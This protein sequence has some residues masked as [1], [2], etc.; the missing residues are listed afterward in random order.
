MSDLGVNKANFF[1]TRSIDIVTQFEKD[2][3]ITQ[4]VKITFINNSPQNTNFGGTYKNYF[5]LF[6]PQDA[7]IENVEKDGKTLSEWTRSDIAY[8]NVFSTFI[9][10]APK[11]TTTLTVR[12]HQKA[13]AKKDLYQLAIQKQ[14]GLLNTNVS[15][16]FR[17]PK[18]T[19]LHAVNF[20]SLE[21]NGK[22]LY[23]TQL[24][25]DKLFLIELND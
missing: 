6:F 11:T 18:G 20:T 4:T 10:L 8:F 23:N 16:E 5:R 12:Y 14:I 19:L 9:E 15:L 22:L 7:I 2:R 24:S 17:A 13:G 3:S 21:K 1:V 25:T